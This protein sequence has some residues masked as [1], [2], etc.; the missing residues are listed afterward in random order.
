MRR[1]ARPAVLVALAASA[2]LALAGCTASAV[3]RGAAVATGNPAACP[4]SVVTVV[5]SVSQWG[6]IADRLGGTCATVTTVLASPAVDPHD[7]EPGTAAVAAFSDAQLVVLNGEGYDQWAVDTVANLDPAPVVVSAA[8]VAHAPQE[9]ANP[10]LWYDPDAVQQ[11]AR[12]I[13]ARLS[14]LSPKA[15]GYFAGR[16]ATWNR[17][18]QPYLAEV[19]HLKAVAAGHTYAATETVFDYLARG[20]GLT[21]VTPEGYRRASSNGSDPA[22]GDLTAFRKELADGSVDVLVYNTQTSGTVPEE[23]RAAARAAGV[24]VLD[25]TESP[26]TMGGSFLAWQTAQLQ[27]LARDLGGTR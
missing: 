8:T 24:P 16:A 9:G 1:V 10:H 18:L 22:P 3:A 25:V 27:Q 7:F 4:G 11:M 26:P 23:L 20:I 21:D 2:A 13:T 15:A 6:D 5:V 14:S 19:A 17:D 12:A